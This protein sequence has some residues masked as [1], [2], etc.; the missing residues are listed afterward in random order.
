MHNPVGD[1]GFQLLR[2]NTNEVEVLT[3]GIFR[4]LVNS[5][6]LNVKGSSTLFDVGCGDFSFATVLEKRLVRRQ[7][8][9][10]YIGIDLVKLHHQ[11]ERPQTNF[12]FGRFEYCKNGFT[13][14]II[15]KTIDSGVHCFLFCH[16]LGAVV[17]SY[18]HNTDEIGSLLKRLSSKNQVI[19]VLGSESSSEIQSRKFLRK[20][21]NA[22]LSPI[23]TTESLLRILKKWSIT[24]STLHV[25]IHFTTPIKQ[26]SNSELVLIGKFLFHQ[27]IEASRVHIK[28]SDIL[29]E[30]KKVWSTGFKQTIVML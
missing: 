24:Y 1:Q 21:F 7:V 16:S 22:V 11:Q 6:S 19:V 25:R 15:E 3:G 2:N 26:L 4:C 17:S 5:M 18:K 8:L 13:M 12:G 27:E 23:L 9:M 10:G 28:N 14:E 30:V 20:K 29:N